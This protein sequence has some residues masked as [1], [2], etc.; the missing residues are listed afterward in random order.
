M[1]YIIIIAFGV[2]ILGG[3][4]IYLYQK[5]KQAERTKQL[6]ITLKEVINVKKELQK[7]HNDDIS[8]VHD[9]LHKYTRDR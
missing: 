6:E 5:G 1:F 7:H 3:I 4:G 9:K 8:V 2:S